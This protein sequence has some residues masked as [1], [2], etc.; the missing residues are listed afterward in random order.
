[1]KRLLLASLLAVLA[2][3][4][5]SAQKLHKA[6]TELDRALQ[7]R[8]EFIE[9]RLA[10]V[11][12]M[13]AALPDTLNYKGLRQIAQAYTGICADSAIVYSHTAQEAAFEVNDSAE[14]RASAILLGANLGKA[15]LFD[16]AVEA[17]EKIYSPNFTRVEKLGYYGTLGRIY[18]DKMT[19]QTLSRPK[20]E[21]KMR[22]IATLDSSAVLLPENSVPWRMIKAQ[23]LFLTDQ[24]TLALGEMNEVI[25]NIDPADPSYAIATALMASFY[26]GKKDRQEEYAYYLAV[27]AA[28]DARNANLEAA[29]LINLGSELFSRGDYD[30]AYE[31]LSI[32]GEE[33]YSSG[34]KSL[35]VSI[36]PT[37]SNVIE[38]MQRHDRIADRGHIVM[39]TV[40]TL[41]ILALIFGIWTQISYAKKLGKRSQ[42]L[43][44]S[45]SSRDKYINQLLDMCSV[46]VESFEDANKLIAR[47]LKAGQSADLLQL[48]ESGKL[49][50]RQTENFFTSFD[51]A[52]LNIFPNFV[53]DVNALL[54]PDQQ[55]STPSPSKLTPELRIAAFMRLGLD[56]STKLARFLGLSL[57]TVYT[58]RNRMKNR[59]RNRAEFE[60][61]VRN[62]GKF[63]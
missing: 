8:T 52:V 5:S 14:G 42:G 36:V 48:V 26:K 60:R 30:R 13:K 40:L 44:E 17:L 16:D 10:Q 46:Y 15:A 59:A 29:S 4:S 49:M 55:L 6:L 41:I 51:K 18:L 33:I 50:Q 47:K 1:M 19:Y 7:H 38:A 3:C 61:E 53:D 9:A 12:S 31:Y 25:E 35:Y 45:L 21:A 34:D 43:E 2:I 37:L 57:N 39:Y 56:D 63:N 27:S 11:D 23:R 58:Y 24:E 28:A 22:A 54:L 20:E 32:A 62:I